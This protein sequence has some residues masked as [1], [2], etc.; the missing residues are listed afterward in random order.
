[1][2]LRISRQHWVEAAGVLATATRFFVRHYP[3]V[4]VFGAVASLQRFL[5][6]GGD[7]RFAFAGGLAG[8]LVTAAVR[9]LFLVWLVRRMFAGDDIG[10]SQVGHRLGRFGRTRTGAV[11]ATAVMLVGLT[12]VAK[13]IP[14]AVAATLPESE[15]ATYLSWELAIKNVT[16]I[17]FT[18]V[19][20]TALSRHAVR[21]GAPVTTR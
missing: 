19:W 18:M 11:L 15:R 13:V 17:P 21:R 16:V 12:I 7:D 2:S 6:V 5:A 14:D 8:E 10:W 4:L 9:V 20:L 3:I 1:M